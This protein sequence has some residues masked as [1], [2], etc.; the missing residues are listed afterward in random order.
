MERRQTGL[1]PAGDQRMIEK[2]PFLTANASMLE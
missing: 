2:K 1:N